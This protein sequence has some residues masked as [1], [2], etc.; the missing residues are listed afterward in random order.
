[1]IHDV[2]E[3]IVASHVIKQ[4]PLELAAV[5]DAHSLSLAHFEYMLRKL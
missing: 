1:M 2:T 3:L 4:W 5:R